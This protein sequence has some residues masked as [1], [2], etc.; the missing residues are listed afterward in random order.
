MINATKD[1]KDASRQR[2]MAELQHRYAARPLTKQLHFIRKKYAWLLVVNGARAAKRG[3]DMAASLILLIILSPLLALTA[4][5]IKMTDFGPVFFNQIRIGRYGREFTAYKFRSMIID[6]DKLVEDVVKMSHHENS[7]SYKVKKDP[8]VTWIGRIIRKASI[9]ELPQLWNVFKGDMS[10]V[11][12]RPHV[13]REVD[14]YTLDER[15]RLDVVP[16]ITCIWQISGRA[17]IAFPEQ[18]QLDLEYI[19]SQS[20]WTDIKILLKTIPA[21][22]SARG[23]Y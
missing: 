4:L 8:R 10:L 14:Q 13:H 12:P 16:G 9:D 5:L 2:L 23:A 17:D 11:G 6:A 3:M 22:I 18:F 21:V 1:P 15:K 19:R 7:I 20:L